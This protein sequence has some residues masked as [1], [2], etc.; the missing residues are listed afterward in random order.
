MVF[1]LSYP[2][3]QSLHSKDFL[4]IKNPDNILSR[5]EFNSH[6]KTSEAKEHSEKLINEIMLSFKKGNA[7][8]NLNGRIE[9]NFI[10]DT[11]NHLSILLPKDYVLQWGRYINKISEHFLIAKLVPYGVSPTPSVTILFREQL[12]GND[13]SGDSIMRLPETEG[14]FMLVKAKWLN[15]FD[16]ENKTFI[17]NRIYTADAIRAGVKIAIEIRAGS[18]QEIEELAAIVKAVTIQTIN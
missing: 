6:A 7:R 5:V 1:K 18:Q 14:E 13:L 12:A 9:N 11:T 16:K 17:R 15:Y 2:P 3:S 10:L 8:T 4:I